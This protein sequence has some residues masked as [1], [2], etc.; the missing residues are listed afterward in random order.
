VTDVA[1]AFIVSMTFVGKCQ[2]VDR[3]MATRLGTPWYRIRTRFMVRI[4]L[5]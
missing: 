5:A 3:D 4:V 2:Q 1:D